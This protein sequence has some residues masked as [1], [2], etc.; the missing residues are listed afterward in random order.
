M[1]ARLVEWLKLP[2][3]GEQL[4]LACAI[5]LMIVALLI[6]IHVSQWHW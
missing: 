6:L 5:V 1:I 3:T 4:L 2:I